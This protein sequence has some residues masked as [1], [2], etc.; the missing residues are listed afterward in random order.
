MRDKLEKDNVI[1][2]DDLSKDAFDVLKRLTKNAHTNSFLVCCISE[3]NYR[4]NAEMTAKEWHILPNLGQSYRYSPEIAKFLQSLYPK[5]VSKPDPANSDR[6]PKPMSDLFRH[7]VIWLNH[8]STR[9]ITDEELLRKIC[10]HIEALL[11]KN[12]DDGKMSNVMGISG[13][14]WG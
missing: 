9:R 6:Y 1:L 8:S 14:G 12:K 11:A 2:L 13:Y 5:S 4:S 7:P 3:R 10:Q